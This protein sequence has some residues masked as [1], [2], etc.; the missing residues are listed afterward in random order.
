[1]KDLPIVF[2]ASRIVD[3]AMWYP[4]ALID[5][6]HAAVARGW[7]PHTLMV[8]TKFPAALLSEPLRSFLVDIQRQGVQVCL[9]LTITGMGGSDIEP[10]V[11]AWEDTV[12]AI[13]PVAEFIGD[14]RRIKLRIDPQ[15]RY[16]DA[17]G[18]VHSNYGLFEPIMAA[19]A[20]LGVED[21]AT[22]FVENDMHKKV[23]SRFRK[24]GFTL[25][26]PDDTERLQIAD[27][28]MAVAAKYGVNLSACAVPGLPMGHC[29]DADRLEELHPT[30]RSLVHEKKK[31]LGRPLCGCCFD[32]DLG[33]WPAKPCP[34]GCL[35]CYE[36]PVRK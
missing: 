20:A 4:Q 30:H 8:W 33:G 17:A 35:Y 26:A 22:S 23:T 12:A 32:L 6:Y 15:L 31:R 18:D 29:L 11:P 2:S 19:C 3:L 13:P 28:M 36:N 5:A 27:G 16:R 10:G 14:V 34:S 21:F 1:M 9:Q 7:D 24:E 25:L